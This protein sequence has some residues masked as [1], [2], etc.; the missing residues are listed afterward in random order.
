MRDT[1]GD[2]SCSEMSIYLGDAWNVLGVDQK[3][4]FQK[5]AAKAKD[6]HKK[7]YPLYKYHPKH[8][9]NTLKHINPSPK[10]KHIKGSFLRL[11]YKPTPV[12]D[13]ID[14]SY[15]SAF[16]NTFLRGSKIEEN[17]VIDFLG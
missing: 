9:K 2:L 12:C 4:H 14:F 3:T 16:L 5:L 7:L 6:A 13:C 1:Y 11:I 8:A 15:S 17:T 10:H